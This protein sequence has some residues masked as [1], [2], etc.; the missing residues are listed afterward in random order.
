VQF[1]V[2]GG[3]VGAPVPVNLVT[4]NA[5]FAYQTA[6]GQGSY[7]VGATFTPANPYFLGS[8]STNTLEVTAEDALVTPWMSNPLAQKVSSPGGTAGPVTF[9]ASVTEA[10]D[11]STLG[12]ISN[13]TVTCTLVPLLSGTSTLTATATTSGGGVGGTLAA[14][15]TFPSVPVN[16]YDVQFSVDGNY[17]IGTAH[18]VFAVSDP[19]LGF[20]TGGGSFI[21]NGYLV[22]FGLNA[23]YLKNGNP[24][25]GFMYIEHRPSGDLVVQG[26]AMQFLSIVGNRAAIGSKA[27]VEGNGNYGLEATVVDNGEPGV[28]VDQFGLRITKPDGTTFLSFPLTTIT[29]GNIHVPH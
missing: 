7:K 1:S 24:Q 21:Y 10:N 18:S 3:N 9:N 26:V 12:D 19:S 25:G 6:V 13:A 15:C 2:N 20:V 11:D 5:S 17:Y 29:G 16:A 8:S 23:R 14:T 4:G 27:T 22:E 28:N